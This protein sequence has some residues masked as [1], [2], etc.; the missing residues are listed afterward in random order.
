VLVLFVLSGAAG[1]VYEIVWARMLTLVFGNTVHAASTVIAAFMGGLALGSFLFGRLADRRRDTLR[2]YGLL[3]A[4]VAVYALFMPL[5]LRGLNVVYGGLFRSFGEDPAPFFVARF[6]LSFVLLLPPTILMGGTL[7]V[8]TRFFVSRRESLGGRVAALYALNTLGATAGCFAAG[9]FLIERFGVRASN[10]V[11]AAVSLTVAVLIILLARRVSPARS[12]VEAP[13]EM[14]PRRPPARVSERES[15]TGGYSPKLRRLI[16]VSVGLAGFA[17]L[18]YEVIWTRVIIHVVTAS[19]EA[20]AVVLTTFLAGIA[21]GSLLVARWVDRRRR[22]LSLFGAIEIAIGLAAV[23]SIPLLADL[24]KLY[25]Y[26]AHFAP[27]GFWGLTTVRFAAAAAVMAVP[28]L[29]MGAA[30]PVAVAGFVRTVGGA[31]RGV[32]ALYAVNTVGAVAGSLTAGF[33]LL[34]ALGAQHGLMAVALFNLT[35]GVVLWSAEP[36]RRARGIACAAA[37]AAAG[38]LLGAF[39]IPPRAF[40][41]LFAQS[42][43]GTELIY[44]SEDVTATITVHQYPPGYNFQDD[45]RV[46]CTTGVDVAGTDSMLRTTQ[47]LQGHLP[48]LFHPNSGP[49]ALQIGFGSGETTRVVLLEGASKL[50]AVEICAGLVQ[51]APFF[52]DINGLAYKDPRV[53]IIIMDAKN[54]ALLTGETYDIIMNDSIHPR[55]S[56]NASL[57]TV[58]YFADCRRR[59]APGGFMSSWFPVYGLRPEELRMIVRS[60]RTVFPHATMW[61]AYNMVNRHALLLAPVDDVPLRI[62]CREY[63]RRITRPEIQADL[64]VV[65]LNDATFFLSSLVMDEDALREYSEGARLNTDD[66]PLLEYLAPKFVV[67][68]EFAWAA[69]LE[70]LIPHRSDVRELLVNWPEDPEERRALDEE[71]GDYLRS[72]ELVLRG[73]AKGLRGDPDS[74]EDFEAA[75]RITPVHPA[76]RIAR[77]R[78]E[79]EL[80]RRLTEVRN[81]PDNPDARI[82][83]SET[84]LRAGRAEEAARHLRDAAARNPGRVDLWIGLGMLE[85]R[86]GRNDEAVSAYREALEIAPQSVDALNKLALL[87]AERGNHEEA[88]ALLRRATSA[89]PRHP[90][91]WNTL[92]WLLAE[93]GADLDEALR[94]AE[95][96]VS[97]DPSAPHLDTLAWVLFKRGDLSRA[98]ETVRKAL[99]L[100]PENETY[101]ERLRLIEQ[102][103]ESKRGKT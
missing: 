26:V 19:I 39:L 10:N 73:M 60:F 49:R 34:P 21:L 53:R 14:G 51:A 20:F 55:V 47:L 52:A 7:P 16:L 6:L 23:A 15:A 99:D 69:I 62:D 68:D 31:G 43:P 101:R 45:M 86:L 87:D 72:N 13:V 54:Y 65:G 96:A 97:L 103:I 11:A 74:W 58:D 71:L 82:R 94:F 84:Y 66:H 30:F 63:L 29:L 78:R 41:R 57:Y 64:S 76:V 70:S 9:F 46:I 35:V 42:H 83:L 67:N 12:A 102:E 25:A 32:G 8:L 100:S 77:E 40:H 17:S 37:V 75:E 89:H 85:A 56:G 5:I 80:A 18:A 24:Y 27:P 2:L 61:M 33:L 38:F 81:D 4:G 50:D 44:C 3:E 28:A 1:L 98:R 36:G 92:A 88:V 91:A 48:L 90:E 79:G 95:R 93:R 22:L 59:I